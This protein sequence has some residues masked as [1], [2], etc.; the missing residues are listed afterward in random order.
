MGNQPSKPPSRSTTQHEKDEKQQRQDKDK[1][2]EKDLER[3]REKQREKEKEKKVN[4]RISFPALSHSHSKATA[5][6]PSASTESALAQTILQPPI[7]NSN[8]QQH[9]QTTHS[10]SPEQ[11]EKG[12]VLGG[13]ST[14]PAVIN[15]E[16][17]ELEY[18]PKEKSMP[19]QV[20]DTNAEPSI[21]MD[22][23]GCTIP[24]P[25][26]HSRAGSTTSKYTPSIR[27]SWVRR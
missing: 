7:Q 14:S 16:R 3:E 20:P 12:P 1:E 8:L 10:Y 19:M 27:F 13:R 6:D 17:E 9:L 24:R 21:P 22:V 23:P 26:R 18:R 5:A 2:R 4:R 15:E 25:A 11:A